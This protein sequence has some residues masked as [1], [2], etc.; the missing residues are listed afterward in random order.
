MSL[1]ILCFVILLGG[2]ILFGIRLERFRWNRRRSLDEAYLVLGNLVSYLDGY[3]VGGGS[4][5][6]LAFRNLLFEYWR[7][8]YL[9]KVEVLVDGL[10]ELNMD[11]LYR[12]LGE[13]AFKDIRKRVDLVIGH[14]RLSS[15]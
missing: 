12:G 5:E 15:K 3:V 7:N 4:V 9:V 11:A 13:E 6:V 10:R 14:V 1:I 8:F 2:G